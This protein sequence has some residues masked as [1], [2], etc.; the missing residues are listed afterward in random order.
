MTVKDVIASI[1]V[2]ALGVILALHFILFWAYGGVFIHESN[3]IILSIETVMSVAILVFG[4]ERFVSTARSIAGRRAPILYHD[5]EHA[6]NITRQISSPGLAL[7]TEHAANEAF[8]T[9]TTMPGPA[10]RLHDDEASLWP[11][12]SCASNFSEA[13]GDISIHTSDAGCGSCAR[14][15]TL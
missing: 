4:F 1:L 5:G 14:T 2:I 3:K 8:T 15:Q 6:R 7:S 10:G 12:L 13:A 11:L 9:A